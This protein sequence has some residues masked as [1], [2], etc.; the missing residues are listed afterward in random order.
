MKNQFSRYAVIDAGQRNVLLVD[1]SLEVASFV[2]RSIM[3]TRI[4]GI[5][6]KNFKEVDA[7]LA[8]T[9]QLPKLSYSAGTLVLL[10]NP[11]ISAITREKR[12]RAKI[13]SQGYS[14]LLWYANAAGERYAYTSSIELADLPML[15]TNRQEFVDLYAKTNGITAEQA[16]KQI[17]FDQ[18]S[19]RAMVMRRKEILWTYTPKLLA[20]NTQAELDAWIAEVRNDTVNVGAV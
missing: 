20:I 12:E 10:D 11:T 1:Q 6:Y 14:L 4:G 2:Q 17:S 9:D 5:P 19:L 13:L 8:S 15:A 18:Q 3:D 7:L 16:E